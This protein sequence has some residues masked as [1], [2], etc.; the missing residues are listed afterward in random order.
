MEI[1]ET[2]ETLRGFSG[3]WRGAGERIVLVPTMG[4]LHA[5][6]LKLVDEA[7]QIGERVVVSI[8]VNPAQFSEG[9]DFGDYPRTIDEDIQKLS[10]KPVDLVFAPATAEVYPRKS[11]TRVT[12]PDLS[13]ILCGQ[14]RPGHFS[15]VA[16]VVLKLFNMVQP[17]TAVFG[18][19]DFQ[20]LCVIRRMV[21]DLDFPISIHSVA[22]VREADGL[23]MSSRNRYLSL[24]ERQLAPALYRLLREAAAEVFAGAR[25]FRDLEARYTMKLRDLGLRADYFSISSVA[26]LQPARAED[27]DL[28]IL[29]AA[30]LGKARLI[31]NQV[32]HLQ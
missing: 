12:V 19:K 6:H 13:D 16:T 8:F 21:T 24:A 7:A 14:F 29:A 17:Q 26:D 2:I 18:E 10:E 20:Q 3:K 31:D 32:V 23:A 1:V 25:N 9:E 30:W 11:Y 27:R 22:T 28:V 4:N 15:G 5:G